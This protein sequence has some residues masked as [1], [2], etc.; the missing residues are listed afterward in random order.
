M[1]QPDLE[2]VFTAAQSLDQLALAPLVVGQH[3]G[4]L[5]VN[6][7]AHGYANAPIFESC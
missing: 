3:G 1:I 2:A 7:V 6:L 4:N 5:L